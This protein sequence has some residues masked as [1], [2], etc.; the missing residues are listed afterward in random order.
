MKEVAGSDAGGRGDAIEPID[1]GGELVEAVE[2]R[3]AR[4]PV[5]VGRPV[6]AD[7]LDPFQR[8][9]LAPVANQLRLRPA[10]ARK[11]RLE[12]GENIVTEIDPKRLDRR[13]SFSDS[14]HFLVIT[15]RAKRELG[16]H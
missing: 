1:L 12:V 6:A 9:A 2:L 7:L 8:R 3:L 10:R 11:P 13:W 5:I 16:I 15:G 4:T 14:P